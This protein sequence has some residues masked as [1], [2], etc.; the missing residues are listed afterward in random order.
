MRILVVA[1]L[2]PPHV[3]GGAEISAANLTRWLAR[4]G[5]EMAVLTAAGPGEA[6]IHGERV[7]GVRIWRMH[8][9]HLY[10]VSVFPGAPSWQKPVWHLQDHVDPRSRGLMA[11]VLDAFRPDFVNVH[12]L[13]GLGYTG[14]A[15]IAARRVPVLYILPD[16]GLACIRMSMYRDGQDCERPCGACRLSARWK[17]H[18]TGRIE[19]LGFLSPSRAN[20]AALE[21]L[22]VLGTRPRLSVLN[23]NRYPPPRV[24]RT[25][26][27]SPRLL[28]VGRLHETKGVEEL[29]AALAPLASRYRFSIDILGTGPSEAP[30]RA[31][32]GGEPWVGFHGRVAAEE[33]SDR[34]QN[35][36]LL[37]VPSLWRENAPGVAVQ[38]LSLGLPVL[39]SNRGGLPELV[40]PGWNGDLLPAGDIE[41]WR[42]TLQSVF[43][44]PEII[45]AW[46]RNA[47]AEASTGRF[48]QDRLGR[49]IMAF[50]ASIAGPGW[51]EP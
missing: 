43:R 33:V 25:S 39:A 11:R 40:R 8:A 36:D 3:I 18:L 23:P 46:R 21:E 26:S 2:Y 7:D 9:P 28:Y 44:A 41:A 45:A 14:L 10:P 16:L 29:L 32:Y 12:I 37:C 48:D 35:A 31:R 24:A 34:M 19:R 49:E 30:L 20:L 5:H 13:Q 1:A 4:Q 27:D 15:A 38:A 17:L 51:S 6:E 42:A 50:M 22:G 47:E